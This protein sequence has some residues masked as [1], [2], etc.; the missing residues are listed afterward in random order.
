MC[1]SDEGHLSK[2][3]S[4]V[5]LVQQL[6]PYLCQC[7]WTSAQRA[8]DLLDGVR[9]EYERVTGTLLNP[10]PRQKRLPDEG[11][12]K[13]SDFLQR[14][15]F[16][17][18]VEPERQGSSEAPDSSKRIMANMLGLDVPGVEPSTSFFPGY[19]WWPRSPSMSSRSP[20]TLWP[21]GSGVSSS[22]GQGPG[23]AVITHP[24]IVDWQQGYPDSFSYSSDSRSQP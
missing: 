14:K 8:V 20:N 7:T 23:P 12:E 1:E 2:L 10:P 3:L 18:N 15:A 22:D 6:I 16:G 17:E 4:Y 9:L 11:G 24:R 19:E 5:P 21:R 13:S